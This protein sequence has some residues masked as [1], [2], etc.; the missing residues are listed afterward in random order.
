[1]RTIRLPQ[2]AGQI[3][4]RCGR[5]HTDFTRPCVGLADPLLVDLN[6]PL[7]V[8]MDLQE[9]WTGADHAFTG[10]LPNLVD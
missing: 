2:M 8:G 9:A 3:Q 7:A 6:G 1:M 4:A 5:F 10:V